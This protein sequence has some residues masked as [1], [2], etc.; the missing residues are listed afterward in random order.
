MAVS[1]REG[2]E[3]QTHTYI[4]RSGKRDEEEAEEEKKRGQF[5]ITHTQSHTTLSSVFIY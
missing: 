2:R 1:E 3:R 5:T 4:H